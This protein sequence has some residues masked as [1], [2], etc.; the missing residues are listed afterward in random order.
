[1]ISNSDITV[2][3]SGPRLRMAQTPGF[4]G[5]AVYG[6]A[7]PMQISPT[8][9][10]VFLNLRVCGVAVVD[11]EAG[12]DLLIFDHLDQVR[13]ERAVPLLRTARTTHPTTGEEIVLVQ[14]PIMGGFVPLGALLPD[15]TP[16]PH[17]GTGFGLSQGLGY[18]GD[19]STT[20]PAHNEDIHR[21]FELHQFR[22]DGTDFT[23]TSSELLTPEQVMPG[24]TCYNRPINNA[25]A[26]GTDLLMAMVM[27]RDGTLHG[28]GFSRWRCGDDG[29]RPVDYVPVTDYDTSFEPGLVRDTD[30]SLLFCARGM[31]TEGVSKDEVA[32]LAPE[33]WRRIQVWRST[34]NGAQWQQVIS[35]DGLRPWSPVVI[36]TTASGQPFIAG[37]LWSEQTHGPTGKEIKMAWRRS[38]LVLWPLNEARDD[39][40]EP[41]TILDGEAT[42]GPCPSDM[43]WYLDH[44]IGAVLR[45]GDGKW[46]SL[47]FFRVGD[48]EEV[49][50]DAMPVPATGTWI[51]EVIDGGEVQGVWKF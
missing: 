48:I 16:H 2:T 33:L 45:L 31:G 17:A 4:E 6:L 25:I 10:A 38:Q 13:E 23:V 49:I 43:S 40:E 14:Y 20:R 42:L 7:A 18:P 21:I 12:V 1:M 46:H 51:E 24:W 50:S 39:V 30:G 28:S 35:R 22:Y 5:S 26:D 36:N 15:G 8:E 32:K 27:G 29:W 11:L 34:D 19:H 9:V 41:I 44:P 3:N 37:N 47:V